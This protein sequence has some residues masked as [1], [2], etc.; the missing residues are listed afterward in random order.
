[1]WPRAESTNPPNSGPGPGGDEKLAVEGGD[2]K[3]P[4]ATGDGRSGAVPST[5][6]PGGGWGSSSSSFSLEMK[7]SDYFREQ[8]CRG[9]GGPQAVAS[10]TGLLTPGRDPPP[11]SVSSIVLEAPRLRGGQ[12]G[13]R[14]V[15]TRGSPFMAPAP[16]APAPSSPPAETSEIC[17]S[18]GFLRAWD[19]PERWRRPCPSSSASVS[20]VNGKAGAPR[21]RLRP[22]SAG[23]SQRR[24][25]C[26]RS[27]RH[28]KKNCL[29]IG[30]GG[31]VFC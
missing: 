13:G 9:E 1:M 19:A 24:F 30:R 22:L 26:E 28:S 16:P 3:P 21:S 18:A 6:S 17:E 8:R 7:R 2:S 11:D 20:V 29:A 5:A 23:L 4:V 31:V 25:N 15:P 10:S 14:L 27:V 12:V